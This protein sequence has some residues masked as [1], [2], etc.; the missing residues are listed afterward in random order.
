MV[1]EENKSLAK[2]PTWVCVCVRAKTTRQKIELRRFGSPKIIWSGTKDWPFSW[3]DF[4]YQ[5]SKYILF[6]HCRSNLGDI[7]ARTVFPRLISHL[8]LVFTTDL[9]VVITI[10]STAVSSYLTR[11]TICAQR[12]VQLFNSLRHLST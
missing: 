4:C 7:I 3:L 6:R 10:S 1:I 8:L 2:V 9:M 5:N 12:L 11:D